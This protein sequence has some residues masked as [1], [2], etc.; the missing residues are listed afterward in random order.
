MVLTTPSDLSLSLL[1]FLSLCFFKSDENPMAYVLRE[2]TEYRVL[3]SFFFYPPLLKS[4]S[5]PKGIALTRYHHRGPILH[6][7]M[8]AQGL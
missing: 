5:D 1:L 2:S 6:I 8:R 4:S 3:I 7:L